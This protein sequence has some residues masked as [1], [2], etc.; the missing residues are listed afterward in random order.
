MSKILHEILNDPDRRWQAGENKKRE[1]TKNKLAKEK[2]EKKI[3]GAEG[4]KKLK[5]EQTTI[6]EEK[7][8]LL[9]S[10]PYL[11][12][13]KKEENNKRVMGNFGT[14][15]L[16]RTEDG[17]SVGLKFLNKENLDTIKREFQ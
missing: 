12:G 7:K 14:V 11:T 6:D 9:K 17:N 5:E 3:E 8:A 2:E 1:E 15:Y 16:G 4:I 13:I 10:P